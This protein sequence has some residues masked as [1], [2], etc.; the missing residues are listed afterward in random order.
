M[1]HRQLCLFALTLMMLFSPLEGANRQVAVVVGV[2]DYQPQPQ[3]ALPDLRFAVRDA[4][5]LGAALRATGFSA[6]ILTQSATGESTGNAQPAATAARIRVEIARTLNDPLLGA[7]D[8]V[9]I[10]LHGHG[11]QFATGPQNTTP[12]FYFCPADADLTGIQTAA[13]IKESHHL[14][15]LDELYAELAQCPA[16]TK[17]LVVDACRNDPTQPGLFRSGVSSATLP[18]V[19]APPGGLIALFSCKQNER[20]VE[21]AN[22]QQGVFSH[23]LVEGL[24]GK[25]DQPFLGNDPDGVVTVHELAAY[26]AHQTKQFVKDT[27][28]GLQQTPEIKGAYDINLPLVSVGNFD[29]LN[30][31]ELISLHGGRVGNGV[32]IE[33]V[34]VEG[35][36]FDY[37]Q[38]IRAVRVPTLFVGRYEVTVGQF[39]KFV[40]STRY[41]T[42]A[43]LAGAGDFDALK[44]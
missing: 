29:S 1:T 37:A 9:L 17:I 12:R 27:Y 41:E 35:G 3:A 33:F 28:G 23:F 2:N 16:A 39:R 10:S 18:Q 32:E 38:G 13:D 8:Y 5:V 24:L 14:I 22:L 25:A 19:P 30:P 21:D 7:G 40:E 11:V 44:E 15:A 26:V 20:A 4:D 31:N 36:E 6:K 34:K 43:E 42:I